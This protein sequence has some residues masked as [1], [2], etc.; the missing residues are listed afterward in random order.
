[1]PRQ[2]GDHRQGRGRFVAR[3]RSGGGGGGGDGGGGGGGRGDGRP[4]P[5]S[6]QTKSKFARKLQETVEQG[7]GLG[8]SSSSSPHEA[9]NQRRPNATRAT[10]PFGRGSDPSITSVSGRVARRLATPAHFDV[11][12]AFDAQLESNFGPANDEDTGRDGARSSHQLGSVL[13]PALTHPEVDFAPQTP[14]VAA[15][16]TAAGGGSGRDSTPSLVVPVSV[17]EDVQFKV[18]LLYT[19]PS[20]RDRG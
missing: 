9:L 15:S 19:S 6:L 11:S 17:P 2:H 5:P 20:P 13:T 1:M 12:A 8:S 3:G 18:C 7:R 14:V 10:A 4:T 16:A